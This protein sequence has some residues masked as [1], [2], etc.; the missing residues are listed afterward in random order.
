MAFKSGQHHGKRADFHTILFPVN[1]S[2]QCTEVYSHYEIQLELFCLRRSLS[3]HQWE[4]RQGT[5]FKSL[6][7]WTIWELMCF[8][9][10]GLIIHKHAT[11]RINSLHFLCL[12][13][14]EIAW[15]KLSFIS[16][17]FLYYLTNPHHG[18][19]W[20]PPRHLPISQLHSFS[21][22]LWAEGLGDT[23]ESTSQNSMQHQLHQF[24]L[25]LTEL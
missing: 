6:K 21:S 20:C 17:Y 16:K 9:F 24:Y 1:S 13:A 12:L 22:F 18:I 10:C 8:E 5:H 3:D 25:L 7:L 19:Q 11:R 4:P 23:E 14:L 2:L 15:K